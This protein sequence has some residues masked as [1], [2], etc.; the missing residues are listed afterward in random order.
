MSGQADRRNGF[1]ALRLLFATGVILSHAPQM[2]DG[3]TGREPLMQLFGGAIDFGRFSVLGFFLISGYLITG[4]Y[5]SDAR[6]YLGKRMLRIYPAFIVCSLL[7]LFV[8]APLGGAALGAMGP[9]DWLMTAARLVSLKSPEVIGGFEGLHFSAL[10]GSMW[11]IIYEFRCY[12]LAMLLGWLGLYARPW[13]YLAMTALLVAATFVFHFPIGEQIAQLTRPLDAVFGQLREAVPLT[14]AFACGACFRLFR[15]RYDGRLAAACA[16]AL[17]GAMFV[18]ILV[19][20]ALMTLGAY[21]LFWL[22]LTVK[23]K[24]LL[25][26]NAKDDISYGVY[27]YA[28]PITLLL[29]WY[30]RDIPL[31]A[32]TILT[33][34]GSALAGAVS[35][36]V[37]EKP[38]MALKSRLPGHGRRIAPIVPPEVATGSEPTA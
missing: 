13:L 36:F 31:A 2:L 35:W 27:L 25:T 33:I 29:I 3:D 26:I 22:A 7:C 11:T 15:V 8:V 16:V 4:S 6:G 1:G 28:W 5:I 18:P 20:P 24:P 23:W 21:A 32:L 17:V 9:K 19:Q 12:L 38:A 14:A 34:A 30:W 10:N 37:F